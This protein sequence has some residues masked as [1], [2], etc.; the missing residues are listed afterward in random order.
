MHV[1]VNTDDLIQSLSK[2]TD[3]SS[4]RQ[5]VFITLHVLKS[6]VTQLS[7]VQGNS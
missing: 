2:P 3:R 6:Y 5:L 1:F 4:S 7:K